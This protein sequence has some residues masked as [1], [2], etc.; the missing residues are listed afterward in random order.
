MTTLKLFLLCSEFFLLHIC[1]PKYIRK[2]IH[3]ISSEM[4]ELCNLF[5]NFFR[6]DIPRNKGIHV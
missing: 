6:Y 5:F 2:P 1:M 3:K 4:Y